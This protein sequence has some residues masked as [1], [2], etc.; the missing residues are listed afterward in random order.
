MPG[1]PSSSFKAPKMP[2]APKAPKMP[3]AP[4]TPS[5]PGAP[6]STGGASTD[7]TAPATPHS[8]EPTAAIGAAR[9]LNILAIFAVLTIITITLMQQFGYGLA[10]SY[11]GTV[12]RSALIGVAIGPIL[13]LLW[14]MSPQHYA[15]SLF[16]AMI[17]GLS[18]GL[19][20]LRG[21]QGTLTLD[22]NDIIVGLPIYEWALIVFVGAMV[23][24]GC[25]LLWIKSWAAWDHGITNH[26]SP[27]RA[28]AYM[29]IIWLAMYLVLIIIQTL[30]SCGVGECQ[31]NPASTG[32]QSVMFTFSVN[33]SGGNS[34][35]ISIPGFIS[36]LIFMGL[37]ALI[38][39]LI[40]NHRQHGAE[41]DDAG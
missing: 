1:F 13:N 16:A 2:T 36:V 26:R 41:A 4:S 35:S 28:I 23:S 14:G 27:S 37:V 40:V 29:T 34:A 5:L 6:G 3:K 15:V 31:T 38:A 30:V 18:S 7:S 19:Q 32:S 21:A 12:Q 11:L 25:M 10:P 39:G 17:G 22:P 9:W 20:M 24:I 8:S 33:G